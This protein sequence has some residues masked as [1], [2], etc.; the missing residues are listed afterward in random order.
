MSSPSVQTP[1]LIVPTS[2]PLPEYFS[3]DEQVMDISVFEPFLSLCI[4]AA[5]GAMNTLMHVDGM[6]VV[7]LDKQETFFLSE[8]LYLLTVS[9][10]T[11]LP[12]KD[13]RRYGLLVARASEP[14]G[15]PWFPVPLTYPERSPTFALLSLT[16][17]TIST[18]ARHPQTLVPWPASASA[19]E[20]IITPH[21]RPLPFAPRYASQES[22]RPSPAL[23][24]THLSAPPASRRTSH[25]SHVHA[26][27]RLRPRQLV[28]AVSVFAHACHQH[29]RLVLHHH[30]ALLPH[31]VRATSDSRP[32]GFLT[33]IAHQP[34]IVY[35]LHC[36][37][38]S[39]DPGCAKVDVTTDFSRL[40]FISPILRHGILWTLNHYGADLRVIYLIHHQIHVPALAI[41]HARRGVTSHST[42]A[43]PATSCPGADIAASDASS[44]VH[45]HPAVC[46]LR[47]HSITTAYFVPSTIWMDREDGLVMTGEGIHVRGP[48]PNT[49]HNAAHNSYASPHVQ[50][51]PVARWA[52]RRSP[53]TPRARP[54][55]TTSH[56]RLNYH[57]QKNRE[58]RFS[59]PENVGVDIHTCRRRLSAIYLQDPLFATP[60]ISDHTRFT[61]I[62]R[63]PFSRQGPVLLDGSAGT[64]IP[65]AS[66]A[67]NQ[68]IGS[69]GI[70]GMCWMQVLFEI[71]EL[72]WRRSQLLVP[73]SQR[74]SNPLTLHF[75]AR[76]LG[77]RV[78]SGVSWAFPR[79]YLVQSSSPPTFTWLF[80]LH[81]RTSVHG[82][83]VDGLAQLSVARWAPS[84]LLS[85]L[86]HSTFGAFNFSSY[87]Q[88]APCA[89]PGNAPPAPS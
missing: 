22:S 20:T 21:Q 53:A 8:T 5:W 57:H 33:Y 39:C 59:D 31:L 29:L 27:T 87:S 62:T 88:A 41:T 6:P 58:F 86:R 3:N 83:F 26:R 65:C 60:P 12:L 2:S 61:K 18:P 89:P 63:E 47:Y 66:T 35:S 79:R 34:P 43:F 64:L 19:H 52:R 17:R 54:S 48:R 46:A 40:Q 51:T 42:A 70:Q 82:V 81:S 49:V 50:L 71:P 30:L 38:D 15:I 80:S 16:R 7:P 84:F 10:G 55:P 56:R 32:R 67:N 28:N 69:R 9:E 1:S 24:P 76:S 37:P 73:E 74:P 45:S 75:S 23:P 13:Q 11:L 72:W 78:G 25:R 14:Q 44:Q 68:R 4:S 77:A 36:C 85:A